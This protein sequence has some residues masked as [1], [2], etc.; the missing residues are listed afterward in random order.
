MSGHPIFKPFPLFRSCHLQTIAASFLTFHKNPDSI[1]RFVHLPDGERI[2]LEVTTPK[3]WKPDHPTVMMIHGLCGSHRSIYLIRL[4]HKFSKKGI[5]SIR[6]NLRGFGSS[7]GHAKKIYH[8]DSSEDIW[9]ALKEVKQDAP[10][11]PLTLVGFSLG[12]NIALKLAGE[13]GEEINKYVEKVIAVN[14]PIDMHR[15]AKLIS[16]NRIYQSYFM[17]CLKEE[18]YFR[19]NYFVDLP[20][21][22]IPSNMSLIEFDEFYMAPQSGFSS[23]K[24]YYLACSSGRSLPNITVQCQILFAKD[25]PIVDCEIVES[26]PLPSNIEVLITEKGGHLGFLGTPG[27]K[28]GFYWMDSIIL[29]WVTKKLF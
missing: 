25:D 16:E 4:A 6:V 5:R 10:H 28:G 17:K 15:S 20:P 22:T 8:S 12:G 23:A 27:K 26:I 19:H 1:T 29:H 13:R 24:E 7:K 2:T 14:P 3:G 18:V 11:S 9:A 21:I